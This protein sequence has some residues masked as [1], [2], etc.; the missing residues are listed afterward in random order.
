MF[1]DSATIIS[2]KEIASVATAVVT[3]GTA[4]NPTILRSTNGSSSLGKQAVS[5]FSSFIAQIVDTE[6]QGSTFRDVIVRMKTMAS[7]RLSLADSDRMQLLNITLPLLSLFDLNQ[8][9]DA[10]WAL[11]TL[12]CSIR[13]QHPVAVEAKQRL[14]SVLQ[15]WS[16]SLTGSVAHMPR[17]ESF[18][19]LSG[20]GKL[21]FAWEEI[22][23]A[24]RSRFL[25]MIVDGG[26]NSDLDNEDTTASTSSSGDY[27][28]SDASGEG[29]VE[30]DLRVADGPL[31]GRELA[32]YVY[33]L[34]QLGVTR[35]MLGR[36]SESLLTELLARL[37][38]SILQGI[39]PQGFSNMLHGMARLGVLWADLPVAM[40]AD[41]VT[42][43]QRLLRDMKHEEFI[44][45]LQ[46][47][48]V[49]K[50]GTFNHAR[51]YYTT[52][53]IFTLT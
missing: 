35:E 17:V 1:A 29:D 43:L 31:R 4:I 33:T 14:V 37:T 13:T 49:M 47:L 51:L 30:G 38:P 46:S 24:V 50:V 20:L 15:G 25:Y 23:P 36:E 3:S 12:K 52:S 21:G 48:A 5:E 41:T 28:E 7:R 11:G 2:S 6:A 44:S 26:V 40:Q 42:Y 27:Y 32:A 53:L 34:G 39:N 45:Q 22:P 18:R 10:I 9:S 19:L 8:L 16:G